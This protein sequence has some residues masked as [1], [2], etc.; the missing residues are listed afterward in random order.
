M[1]ALR[2]KQH[3]EGPT[4]RSG[5]CLN[6]IFTEEMSRTKA[7]GC[8]QNMFVSDHNSIQCVLD[9]PKENCTQKEITYRKLKDVD[10]SQ[11]VKDMSL[12]EIK[13]EKLDEMV[14]ML[15]ENFSTALN[16]QA[17][18]ITEFITDR[19][20]KPWFGDSLK[21]QK[22]RVRRREK[23]FRIYRLQSCW[24]SF[25]MESKKYRKFLVEAKNACYGQQVKDCR[26]DTRGL[27][28]MINTLMFTFSN[29]P[30]PNH[31]NNMDLA[32]E[33]AGFFMDKIQKI[34]DN[35]TENLIYKP[36]R[37]SIPS[38]AEFRP[39]DQMEVKNIILSMKTKSCEL[40]ALPMKLLKDCLDT[41]LPTITNIVNISLQD[42]IFASGW[43]TSVIR[44]LLKKPT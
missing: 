36:T 1:T 30:L 7:I 10:I 20:K 6:L 33:F 18:E 44:P 25:D 40:D 22:R 4:H 19:R 8:S 37:K 9:I 41:I 13:T 23:V 2:L 43:K 42:G 35:L 39:F 27:Y 16:N 29:N 21:Q 38:L 12:E 31:A 15:E 26:G 14:A 17:P 34:R 32:E 11:L 24:I 5:N 28:K 3:V